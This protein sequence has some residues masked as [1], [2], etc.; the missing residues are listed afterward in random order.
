MELRRAELMAKDLI[1]EHL[2]GAGWRFGWH[3]RV[4][5]FG[6]CHHG[7]HEIKLSRPL[8]FR[9]DE[10][11]IRNVLLH[12]IAHALVGPGNGHNFA[13]K[14]MARK[15]GAPFEHTKSSVKGNDASDIAPYEWV[16]PKGHVRGVAHRLPN[17]NRKPRSCGTCSPHRFDSTV[18]LT[19]RRRR[20]GVGG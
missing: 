3:Q 8:T 18:I 15:I 2:S 4:T 13:F 20:V 11:F 5:A 9:N 16:C 10:T 7:L 12:E 1:A 14:A 6:T 19:I 17:R